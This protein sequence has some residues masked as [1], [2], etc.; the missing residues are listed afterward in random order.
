MFV[1]I[2][3]P[4]PITHSGLSNNCKMWQVEPVSQLPEVFGI[5]ADLGLPLSRKIEPSRAVVSDT[6]LALDAPLAFLRSMTRRLDAHPGLGL[7][8]PVIAVPKANSL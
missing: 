6:R 5:L 1:A 3:P 2:S 8:L 7:T 4:Q